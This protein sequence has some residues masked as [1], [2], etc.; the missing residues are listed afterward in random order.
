[1][2]MPH[3]RMDAFCRAGEILVGIVKTMQ[4]MQ[5]WG[6]DLPHRL[7]SEAEEALRH[8]PSWL[9]LREAADDQRSMHTWMVRETP[10]TRQQDK[11]YVQLVEAVERLGAECASDGVKID[12]MGYLQAWLETEHLAF[13][14]RQPIEILFTTG[15]PE[16]IV[17]LFE[18]EHNVAREAK[19]VFKTEGDAFGWLRSFHSSLGGIPIEMLG[20][21][22]GKKKVRDELGRHAAA[23]AVRMARVATTADK[24][25]HDAGRTT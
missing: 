20:S 15:N 3:Q 5:T 18:A 4:H 2:T 7:V 9:E 13:G 22:T 16:R 19:R 1:M 24:A 25:A 10:D 11:A 6:A 14:C 12:T 17:E 8:Y 23:E 21:E